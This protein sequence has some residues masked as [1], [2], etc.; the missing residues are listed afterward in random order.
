MKRAA[1]FDMDRTVVRV[2]TA[3]LYMRWR[4]GRNEAG[5]RDMARFARWM[6]QYTFGVIDPSD[7]TR[8]AIGTLAGLEEMRFRR[9]LEEWFVSHVVGEISADARTEIARARSEG[10]V[11]AILSASTPYAVEPLARELNI[12]HAL[13]T[14]LEIGDGHFT[15]RCEELCYGLGQVRMAERWAR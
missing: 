1:F 11:I 5:L 12:E 14:V 8:K 2:N 3:K 4:Y 7:I 13:C 10:Y 6:A 9:E 15:G